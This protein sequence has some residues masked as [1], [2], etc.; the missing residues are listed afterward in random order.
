MN[1]GNDDHC[2]LE[3]LPPRFEVEDILELGMKLSVPYNQEKNFW[4]TISP[5]A[6]FIEDVYLSPHQDVASTHRQVARQELSEYEAEINPLAEALA[7]KGIRL[8]YVFN[9]FVVSKNHDRILDFL[10]MRLSRG[11]PVSAVFADVDLAARVKKE[12]PE[13]KVSNS[14]AANMTSLHVAAWWKRRVGADVI[15]LDHSYNLFPEKLRQIK[16]LGVEVKVIPNNACIPECPLVLFHQALPTLME[17]DPEE[18]WKEWSIRLQKCRLEVQKN[19]WV[20]MRTMIA[21]KNLV[22]YKGCVDTLKLDGRS[23]STQVIRSEIE[24]YAYLLEDKILY[25]YKG[26]RKAVQTPEMLDRLRR[27][28]HD[29]E[30]CNWC[31]ETVQFE[32]FDAGD[33]S[34]I[35]PGLQMQKPRILNKAADNSIFERAGGFFAIMADERMKVQLDNIIVESD[36][37]IAQV[38]AEEGTGEIILRPRDESRPLF[39]NTANLDIGYNIVESKSESWSSTLGKLALICARTLELMEREDVQSTLLVPPLVKR[40]AELPLRFRYAHLAAFHENAESRIHE[41]DSPPVDAED[42]QRIFDAFKPFPFGRILVIPQDDAD[43]TWIRQILGNIKGNPEL[44]M[45]IE[46]SGRTLHS[47]RR[48]ESYAQAGVCLFRAALWSADVAVHDAV[49]GRPGHFK[50]VLEVL[51][52]VKK[53]ARAELWL[54]V[55][56]REVLNSIETLLH[57]ANDRGWSILLDM[58]PSLDDIENVYNA[59]GRSE[60]MD[61]LDDMSELLPSD[62][63]CIGFSQQEISRLL[64]P[65]MR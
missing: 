12:L 17:S 36:E 37:V 38:S 61:R 43:G 1:G 24:R 65:Y 40:T 19:P 26:S 5:Y 53:H 49:A 34:N 33:D 39:K 57:L 6:R 7:E 50:Q 11:W 18:A 29:C 20:L 35:T 15:L 14:V 55:A 62:T 2:G 64:A 8:S 51:D 31:E 52:S 47:P 54:H 63:D 42:V 59:P 28:L 9:T 27:C 56:Q 30:V 16:N 21:P 3:I 32:E 23:W 13:I 48:A 10:G 25:E 22:Y 41:Q 4:K 58:H 45:A 46:Y 44:E 60:I